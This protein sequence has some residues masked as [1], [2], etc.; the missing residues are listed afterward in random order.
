MILRTWHIAVLMALL[1]GLAMSVSFSL[2]Q[3]GQPTTVIG[4]ADHKTMGRG[5]DHRGETATWHTVSLALVTE[6]KKNGA[7][8]G[9]TIAYIIDKK[10]FDRIQDGAVVKGRPGDDSKLDVL[11]LRHSERFASS[12]DRFFQQPG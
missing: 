1:V 9:Q 12:D 3:L 4:T 7:T 2:Y 10:D 11:D 8:V 5:T 6:D